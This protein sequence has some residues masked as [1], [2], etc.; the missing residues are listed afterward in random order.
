MSELIPVTGLPVATN[1]RRAER[2]GYGAGWLSG[3]LPLA[4]QVDP[5]FVQ[6]VTIF[7]EVA[8]TLRSGADSVSYA[9]DVD[10][11]A[12]EMVR[13]LGA[14]V[15]AVAV[16]EELTTI[17]Q[18]EIVKAMGAT[19]GLRGT[20][21]AIRTVLSALTRGEV[22]VDDDGGVYKSGR[23]PGASGRVTVEL[24]RAGRLRPP[25]LVEVV[26]A[27]VPA[28]LLVTITCGG[29]QLYPREEP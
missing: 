3:A 17:H 18:R 5:L 24:E 29:T 20:A 19:L 4:M 6:F 28:H 15:G 2:L 14:W 9:A 12:P 10:V 22:A 23:A 27:M 8:S 11:T 21:E 16:N 13:Y 26:L 7:E 25:E 1:D